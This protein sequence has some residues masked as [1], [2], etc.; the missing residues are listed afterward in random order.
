[1]THVSRQS[2]TRVVMPQ[3]VLVKMKVF[4]LLLHVDAQYEH[5]LLHFQKQF[6]TGME[7]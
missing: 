6:L 2:S 3:Q 5:N 1:M 4:M 7:M